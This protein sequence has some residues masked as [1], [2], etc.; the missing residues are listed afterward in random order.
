MLEFGARIDASIARVQEN[1]DS[2]DF[3]SYRMA[4]GRIMA[5]MLIEVMNPL[6]RAHPDL[7]P[8]ELV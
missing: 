6:Y 5:D 8:R 7:K 2:T 3:E 1:C 4:A